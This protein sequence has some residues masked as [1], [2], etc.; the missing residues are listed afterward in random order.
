M[1]DDLTKLN[2]SFLER[3]PLTIQ[4]G[5]LIKQNTGRIVKAT[6]NDKKKNNSTRGHVVPKGKKIVYNKVRN[7]LK[8]Y[9]S[10]NEQENENP[11]DVNDSNRQKTEKNTVNSKQLFNA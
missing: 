9:K 3:F 2:P 10:D 7:A 1:K 8:K 11:T 6:D 5:T 4:K